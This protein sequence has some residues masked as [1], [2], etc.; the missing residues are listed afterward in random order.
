VDQTDIWMLG[1][2]AFG[3]VFYLFSLYFHKTGD[4]QQPSEDVDE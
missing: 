1:V 4:F 3:V 2:G